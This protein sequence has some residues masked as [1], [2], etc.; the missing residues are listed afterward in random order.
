MKQN[1]LKQ[2]CL[3]VTDKCNAH[4][5]QC[6]IWMR[7]P[8]NE[9]SLEELDKFFL[10]SDLSALESISVS[11]GEPIMRDDIVQVLKTIRKYFQKHLII[12]SNCFMPQ[13]LLNVVRQ[14]D[15]IE[16][17]CSLDGVGKTVEK[18]RGVA[19]AF[20]KIMKSMELL[21]EN[22]IPFLIS[23]TIQKDNQ[24]EIE[25]VSNIAKA[26]NV[27]FWCRPAGS[28][29]FF[30]KQ[31]QPPLD[32]NKVIKQLHAIR[33]I[34]PMWIEMNIRYLQLGY[35]PIPCSAGVSSCLI[36]PVFDVFACSHC[37]GDCK[38]GNL[39][40]VEFNLNS[41]LTDRVSKNCRRCLNE[42]AH[43]PL[44]TK[45]MYYEYGLKHYNFKERKVFYLKKALCHP[46]KAIKELYYIA[47]FARKQ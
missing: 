10:N 4:C 35:L 28:G 30:D 37:A 41:L 18:I 38:L 47:R 9:F 13:H 2:I 15:H 21:K 17:C 31:S 19:D 11:G 45:K 44:I 16:V 12:Q 33:D 26:F 27:P 42:I 46:L 8:R 20:G 43:P 22:H 23:M 6:S 24:N 3:V 32:K 25:E 14:I 5:T 39:R 36:S 7:Q 1:K 34:H 40:D 29:H